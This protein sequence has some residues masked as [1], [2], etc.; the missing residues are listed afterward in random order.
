MQENFEKA[1]Y[2]IL[3]ED[4]EDSNHGDSYFGYI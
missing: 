4:K 3:E 2:N 1:E